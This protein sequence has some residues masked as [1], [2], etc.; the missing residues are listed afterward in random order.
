MLSV[1]RL[2][3]VRDLL[4]PL[5]ALLCTLSL[6]R[7]ALAGVTQAQV[8]SPFGT[9]HLVR[10]DGAAKGLVLYL[11]GVRGWD[12]RAT[13]TAR[14]VAEQ[15]HLVAGLEWSGQAPATGDGA[16]CRDLG[17]ELNRLAHWVG[18]RETLPKNALPTVLGESEGAAMVYGALLQSPT[19]RFHAAVTRGFCP[20]WPVV[21]PPC[22]REGLT[23]AVVQ[24]DR[25]LPAARVSAAWFLFEG[26]TDAACP[27]DQVAAFAK[28]VGNARVSVERAN[29]V[30]SG[31]GGAA[32]SP[33]ASLMQWLDPRI[34]DQIAEGAAAQD[35][36][37]LP[38]IEVRAPHEDPKTFA[39]MLSGDGGWAAIDRG[40]S[41]ELAA[42]GISTVGW[43][44]LSY[45]WKPRTPTETAEDLAQV[46]RHYLD[47]W[48]KERVILIGYSFGAEVLPFLAN[49]LPADLRARVAGTAFLGLGRT[50]MFEFHLTD[51][52]NTGR[53]AE[54]L[55]V[56]PQMQALG[57]TRGLCVYGEDEEESLCPALSGLGIKVHKVSGDHHFDGDYPEVAGLILESLAIP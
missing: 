48:H 30:P 10:P 32:L 40:V 3:V 17:D 7:P 21:A 39:V 23:D 55:P 16:Q 52:L 13:A 34:H 26:G 57:W 15:G 14:E 8:A 24:D 12:A 33:M 28:Q 18:E 2:S 54:A 45:F 35:I 51:W 50:A 1:S 4:C 44:S 38:L 6:A 9:I 11:P 27:A 19:H 29:P 49:G 31:S 5:I 22:R 56:L 20:R 53:G 37:G 43:D 42:K 47:A 25:L 41:A 36:A 46:V